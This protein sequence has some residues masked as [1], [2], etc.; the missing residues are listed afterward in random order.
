MKPLGTETTARGPAV[1]PPTWQDEAVAHIALAENLLEQHFPH[2]PAGRQVALLARQAAA[3][4][5]HVFYAVPAGEAK[6]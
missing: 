3:L 6:P 4:L 1:T 5:R 2:D